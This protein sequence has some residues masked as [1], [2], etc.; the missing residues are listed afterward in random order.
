[1]SRKDIEAR[2][3]TMN[4]TEVGEFW[5]DFGG[6][7][8]SGDDIVRHWVENPQHRD[9]ICHLL[10]LE[11][12]DEKQTAAVVS[13]AKSAHRSAL[14][15]WIAAAVALASLIFTAVSTCWSGGS[16]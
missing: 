5:R 6:G 10:S 4:Q 9:R 12:D 14:A 7:E 13:A 1:M 16:G 11:T 3:A 8:H 15:A 2:V